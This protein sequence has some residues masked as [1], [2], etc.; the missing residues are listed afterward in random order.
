MLGYGPQLTEDVGHLYRMKAEMLAP[1]PDGL[2]NIFRLGCRHHENDVIWRLLKSFQKSIKS[3]VG[4]LVGLIQDVDLVFIARRPVTSSVSKFAN[5]IDAAVG[6]GVNLDHVHRIASPY[7]RTALAALTWLRTRA[8]IAANC[9]TAVQGHSQYS[10]DGRLSNAAMSAKDI[11]VRDASLGERI[12]ECDRHV[13]LTGDV[14]EALWAVFSSK[15][16]VSH[17]GCA[18]SYRLLGY[19]DCIGQTGIAGNA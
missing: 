7:L 15:D 12:H 2:R 16:E 1:R 13:L 19:P 11:S 4:N 10:G 3:R 8:E 18:R 9:V 6:R 14:G 17:R 5:L